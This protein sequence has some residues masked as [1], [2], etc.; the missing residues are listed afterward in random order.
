MLKSMT[1][2]YVPLF[3]LAAAFYPS[4]AK[5]AYES[6][7]FCG[8]RSLEITRR[9]KKGRRTDAAPYQTLPSRRI[10]AYKICSAPGAN[11]RT[12]RRSV[13]PSQPDV[14]G[15]WRSSMSALFCALPVLSAVLSAMSFQPCPFCALPVLSALSFQP[16]F[17]PSIGT[18]RPMGRRSL[19]IRT[20][21]RLIGQHVLRRPLN[22]CA[23]VERFEIRANILGASASK[24]SKT[25]FRW[26]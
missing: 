20:A 23:H 1:F 22:A 5:F 8:A 12:H 7:R 6:R 3:L 24:T 14:N 13:S 17:S 26:F 9:P 19:E 21:R 2:R 18:C 15:L 11:R 16:P 10:G 4:W 25:R